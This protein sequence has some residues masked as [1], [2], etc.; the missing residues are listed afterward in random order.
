[1]LEEEG[2]CNSAFPIEQMDGLQYPI[3]LLNIGFGWTTDHAVFVLHTLKK[4]LR[5]TSI[6]NIQKRSN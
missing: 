2:N 3:R 1:M 5:S 6:G 4:A